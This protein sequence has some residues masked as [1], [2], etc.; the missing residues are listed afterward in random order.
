MIKVIVEEDGKKLDE[1]EGNFC[2]VN[3][4]VGNHSSRMLVH[5]ESAKGDAVAMLISGTVRVFEGIHK[6]CPE[7]FKKACAGAFVKTLEE[8]LC[9]EK[10]ERPQPA[11][12]MDALGKIFFN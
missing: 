6:N 2:M 9:T 12:M 8:A 4:D 3:V 5:G 11:S 1:I 10:E 7:W